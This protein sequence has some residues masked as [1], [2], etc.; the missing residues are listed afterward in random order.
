LHAQQDI[1]SAR[2]EIWK[3][4]PPQGE[5]SDEALHEAMNALSRIAAAMEVTDASDD[6][7]EHA[8][9]IQRMWARDASHGFKDLKS[10]M[11]YSKRS[12]KDADLRFFHL[13]SEFTKP[14]SH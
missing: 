1:L 9:T 8:R 11:R 13:L 2:N 6:E 5:P 14:K 7:L 12:K 3:A 4:L 10:A